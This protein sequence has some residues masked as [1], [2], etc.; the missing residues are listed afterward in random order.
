MA[1]P[2]VHYSI[3]PNKS[4]NSY[5]VVKMDEDLNPLQYYYIVESSAGG[6]VCSCP[7]HKPWCRHMDM[8]RLFQAEN[9]IGKGWRYNFDTKEWI[10]PQSTAET[11]PEE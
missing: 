2:T 7:A 3:G 5:V 6:L 1:K 10:E 9:R 4:P 8:L 11:E